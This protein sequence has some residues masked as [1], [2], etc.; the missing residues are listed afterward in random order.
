MRSDAESKYSIMDNSFFSK[1]RKSPHTI[2]NAKGINIRKKGYFCK[3]C[4]SMEVYLQR[5]QVMNDLFWIFVG[6]DEA[7]G[8]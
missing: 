4:A 1:N 7:S 3:L 8:Y 6:K 2:P 5:F